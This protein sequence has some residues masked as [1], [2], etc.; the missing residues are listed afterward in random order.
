M[1]VNAPSSIRSFQARV[2]ENSPLGREHFL[3]GLS[4]LSETARPEP[5]QFYMV[6]TGTPLEPLLKRPF[7][8]LSIEGGAIRMLYR[9]RG[10]GTRLLSETPPGSVLGLLGPLGNS[11]PL[12]GRGRTPVVV[13]GGTAIASVF[14]LVMSLKGRAVVVY[15]AKDSGDLLLLEELAGASKE[16]VI[17]TEDGSRGLKGTPLDALGEMRLDRGHV[18]Y[19]CGPG[20]MTRAVAGLALSQGVQG[21]ASLEEYMACGIGACMGC[22][23]RTRDG[24][25]RVCREGPVFGLRELAA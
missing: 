14:P 17:C 23:T 1:T 25:R 2:V 18:L 4:P 22:V 24:Y 6:G 21:Y 8:Y 19:V 20:A 16:L 13:A 3:L 15:G 5:G 11:Y 12:P 9:V 7:C 10:K